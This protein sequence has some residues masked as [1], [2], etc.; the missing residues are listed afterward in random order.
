MKSVS[1]ITTLYFLTSTLLGNII[2]LIVQS[3]TFSTIKQIEMA[4]E[5]M[6]RKGSG[7]IDFGTSG[8]KF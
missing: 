4:M 1:D 5:S 7:T 8:Q 3:P 6:S 2:I